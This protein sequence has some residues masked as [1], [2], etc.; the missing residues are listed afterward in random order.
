MCRK[1]QEKKSESENIFFICSLCK[2]VIAEKKKG[3]KDD[4]AMKYIMAYHSQINKNQNLAIVNKF[5]SIF[6]GYMIYYLSRFITNICKWGIIGFCA[7]FVD[8]LPDYTK[9]R[10]ETL[11]F[12]QKV[13]CFQVSF[14][15]ASHYL[16]T[17]M[18]KWHVNESLINQEIVFLILWYFIIHWMVY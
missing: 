15:S 6:N 14:V 2:N 5:F 9:E 17:E 3:N 18:N 8:I 13:T 10:T 4:S 1:P 7:C 11:Y 12:V 16:A